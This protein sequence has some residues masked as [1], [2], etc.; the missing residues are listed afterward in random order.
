[1]AARHGRYLVGRRGRRRVAVSQRPGRGQVALLVGVG[2]FGPGDQLHVGP[3]VVAADLDDVVGF[4][5]Q[6][7]GDRPVPVDRDVH[8]RDPHAEVLH[9]GDDLGQVLFRADDEGV[10]DGAVASQRGQVA[11]DLGLHALAP[12]RA[13]LGHAELDA[14]HVGQGVLLGRAAAVHRGLVPVAAEYR[15]PRALPGQAGQQ[16]EETLVVPGNRFAAARPVH[17]HGTIREHVTGVNEQRA[18]IHGPTVLSSAQRPASR[19]RKH[20]TALRVVK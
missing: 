4:L 19:H 6:R 14:R 7:P 20:L 3:Q 5:A 18:A 11:V 8:Q 10:A 1:M 17:R 16:L 2:G 15:Q 13:D 12:A 9:V